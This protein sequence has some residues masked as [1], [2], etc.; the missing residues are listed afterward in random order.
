MLILN[1]LNNGLACDCDVSSFY[2][3]VSPILHEILSLIKALQALH[4]TSP[5]LGA[6]KVILWDI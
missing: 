6:P 4:N 2:N 3:D 1:I 5:L